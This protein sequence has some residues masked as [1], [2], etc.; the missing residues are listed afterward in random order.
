VLFD[1][2]IEMPEYQNIQ[3]RMLGADS[4]PYKNVT[5]T[6]EVRISSTYLPSILLFL[7]STKSPAHVITWF[8]AIR[9]PLLLSVSACVYSLF[10]QHASTPFFISMRLLPSLSACFYSL[11]YQLASTPVFISMRLLPSLL[12]IREGCRSSQQYFLRGNPG[13]V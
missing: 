13:R 12:G 6:N 11:L 7:I 9:M 1:E 3:T 5:I 10:Y 8:L 4:F 2:Y